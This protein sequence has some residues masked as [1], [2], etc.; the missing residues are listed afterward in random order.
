M[1]DCHEDDRESSK[2]IDGGEPVGTLAAPT[3][4]VVAM[5]IVRQVYMHG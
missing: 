5:C 1:I 2:G 4:S 3:E